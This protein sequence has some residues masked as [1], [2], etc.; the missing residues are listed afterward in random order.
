[1]AH[2]RLEEVLAVEEQTQSLYPMH[3]HL[4]ESL[5][6]AAVNAIVYLEQSQGRTA[7][8]SKCFLAT[9][10]Y[11]IST[12]AY[13]D[14]AAQKCHQLDVGILEND[15]PEIPFLEAYTALVG[16]AG[17]IVEGR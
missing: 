5:G 11:A 14:R 9:Q 1:M 8:L 12:S 10:V 6:L 16:D 4:L 7:L 17:G 15:L 2:Q 13:F 3:R